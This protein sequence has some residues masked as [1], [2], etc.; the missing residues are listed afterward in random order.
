MEHHCSLGGIEHRVR[1]LVDFRRQ[2]SRPEVVAPIV[3]HHKV[4]SLRSNILHLR[5]KDEAMRHEELVPLTHQ[6]LDLSSAV[7]CVRE[8]DVFGPDVELRLVAL[9]IAEVREV[10]PILL[11]LGAITPAELHNVRG[12]QGEGLAKILRQVEHVIAGAVIL[13]LGICVFLGRLLV[14]AVGPGRHQEPLGSRLVEDDSVDGG[15][16]P[17][18]LPRVALVGGKEVCPLR[19]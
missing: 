6:S 17:N 9:L 5:D 15:T 4:H 8:V 13:L 2:L 16:L 3:A 14:T 7:V 18:F 1:L 10:D 19:T 12:H 11:L